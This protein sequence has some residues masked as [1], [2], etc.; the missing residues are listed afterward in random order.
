MTGKE[1]PIGLSYNRNT[2]AG[3]YEAVENLGVD[4]SRVTFVVEGQRLPHEGEGSNISIP[5]STLGIIHLVVPLDIRKQVHEKLEE[6]RSMGGKV[7]SR[8]KAQRTPKKTKRGPRSSAAPSRWIAHVQRTRAKHGCS[9]KE[10]LQ[11]ASKTW[12]A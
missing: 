5:L 4:S 12:K 9:Y 3:L 7:S 6:R 2:P 1:K 11:R 10:A 8:R